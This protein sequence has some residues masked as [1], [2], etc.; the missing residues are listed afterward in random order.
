MQ[1]STIEQNV[2]WNCSLFRCDAP[3][4]LW[5][6]GVSE[7]IGPHVNMRIAIETYLTPS[8]PLY[9][10]HYSNISLCRTHTQLCK[11]AMHNRLML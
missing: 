6:F 7:V 5:I 9:Y 10:L 4:W 2:P 11:D 8:T 3:M 1:S